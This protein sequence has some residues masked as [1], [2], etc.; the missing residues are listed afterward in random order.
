MISIVE[1]VNAI[2]NEKRDAFESAFIAS[3]THFLNEFENNNRMDN[4]ITNNELHLYL[5]ALRTFQ[6]YNNTAELNLSEWFK[7]RKIQFLL[8]RGVLNK[9][10]GKLIGFFTFAA[11]SNVSFFFS[12]R[13]LPI[14][15]FVGCRQRF[16]KRGR[17]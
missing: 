7:N 4:S 1:L 13:H 15:I 8:A 10:P 3:I 6:L 12:H 2:L 17:V 14:S 11:F 16:S 9:N 5:L